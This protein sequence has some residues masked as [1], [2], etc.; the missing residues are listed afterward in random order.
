M[1]TLS[2][3]RDCGQPLFRGYLINKKGTRANS[4]SYTEKILQ[5]K[6]I[7]LRIEGSKVIKNCKTHK[8]TK[9]KC[10][11]SI[12]RV[13]TLPY[14]DILR[15]DAVCS[16]SLHLFTVL[17]SLIPYLNT[18]VASRC[19]SEGA[20]V[21]TKCSRT[22]SLSVAKANADKLNLKDSQDLETQDWLCFVKPERSE[23]CIFWKEK[24]RLV[25]RHF[26]L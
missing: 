4:A 10:S 5:A 2:S 22:P 26:F 15:E 1:L 17:R 19:C 24:T 7:V 8:N 25:F 13:D 6:L 21:K 12:C 14:T 9:T 3:L 11:F 20:F 18:A 23:S 16:S